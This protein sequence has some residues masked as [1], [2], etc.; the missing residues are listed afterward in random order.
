MHSSTCRSTYSN[1]PKLM[2]FCVRSRLHS[3]LF[4]TVKGLPHHLVQLPVVGGLLVN[5]VP[6]GFPGAIPNGNLAAISFGEGRNGRRTRNR[7][8]SIVQQFGQSFKVITF[9]V[10]VR[11]GMRRRR[12]PPSALGCSSSSSSNI[13]SHSTGKFLYPCRVIKWLRSQCI[14]QRVHGFIFLT[15][16]NGGGRAIS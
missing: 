2:I 9:P 12:R 3:F 6:R 16:V 8:G 13:C 1:A 14:C 11:V 15:W 10:K 7:W 5:T 4:L